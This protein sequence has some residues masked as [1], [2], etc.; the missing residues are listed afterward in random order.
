MKRDEEGLHCREEGCVGR[1]RGK[2]ASACDD[3]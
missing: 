3:D 2:V 1:F